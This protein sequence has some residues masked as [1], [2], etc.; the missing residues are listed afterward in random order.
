MNKETRNHIGRQF[1][2]ELHADLR[3]G[4]TA[5]GRI[6]AAKI[7]LPVIIHKGLYS[8]GVD[9]PDLAYLNLDLTHFHTLTI[10][11]NHPVLT[12]DIQKGTVTQ[13]FAYIVCMKEPTVI[14]IL[15]IRIPDKCFF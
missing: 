14:F 9:I 3:I 5:I 2:G 8:S 7:G 10:N 6:I 15:R 13:S 12:V 4:N 1:F 11:L